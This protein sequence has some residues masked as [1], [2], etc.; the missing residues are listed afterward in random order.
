MAGTAAMLREIGVT[1][2]VIRQTLEGHEVT[3]AEYDATKAWQARAM[4][5]QFFVKAYLDGDP[6]AAKQMMLASIILSSP[7]KS[8]AAA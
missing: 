2:E 5:D 7:I 6:D 4:R 1:P 3:Q 8:G